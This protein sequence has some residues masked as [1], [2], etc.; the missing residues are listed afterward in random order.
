MRFKPPRE[1]RRRPGIRPSGRFAGASVSPGITGE[2]VGQRGVLLLDLSQA[3][4]ISV[5][6][7]YGLSPS[8]YATDLEKAIRFVCLDYF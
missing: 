7:R 5:S 1:E 3:L 6:T 4:D 2:E 8:I